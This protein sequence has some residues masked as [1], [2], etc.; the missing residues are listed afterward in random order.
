[1][2]HPDLLHPEPRLRLDA[3][4]VKEAVAFSFAVGDGQE[5]LAE[6]F[7]TMKLAESSFDPAQFAG[8]LF[9]D[10]FVKKAFPIVIDG[11]SYEPC[12]ANLARLVCRPPRDPHVTAHRR[13]ILAELSERPDARVSVERTY[14]GLRRFLEV[15]VRS[16]DGSVVDHHEH[17]VEILRA[18]QGVLAEL[19]ASL[20]GA[21]TGL[22]ALFE[23]GEEVRAGDAFSRL[24]QLLAYERSAARVEI[25][26]QVGADGQIRRFELAR[27][28]EAKAS[29]FHRGVWSRFFARVVGFFRGYR[30]GELEVMARLFDEVFAPFEDVVVD[31]FQILLDLEVYLGSLG[32]RDRALSLGLGVC[33]PDIVGA[34]PAELAGA[35]PAEVRALRDLWNPLLLE[36]RVK[37][38]PSTISRRR[39]DAIVLVTGPNSGGK[40]RM[41]QSLAFAQLLGQMGLFVPAA[42]A[43]LGWTEGLFVSLHHEVSASQKEGR[44]GTELVRIR[45]LFEQLSPGDLVLFDELCSG[46]NPSEA[47]AIIRLVLELLTELSP[48]VF[49]TTHFLDFARQLHADPPWPT[50]EFLR[51]DLDEKNRPLFTFVAGVAESALAAETAARLGVTLEELARTVA[52]RKTEKLAFD[53]PE[54]LASAPRLS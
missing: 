7:G 24:K 38:R 18:L 17:R 40:T 6:T 23:Y 43:T 45:Q 34:G 47:E 37:P 48:Q 54:E 8:D 51:A 21:K 3:A 14:A 44:L 46:T 19:G 15:L 33:L 35:P 30:F 20:E 11:E 13:A 28:T 39:L 32:F 53:V 27:I 36:G 10:A 42:S 50:L 25:D 12:R 16:T 52:R 31:L 41:L 4:R 22:G 49:V 29:A 5:L 1:M 9:I 2:R 26:L